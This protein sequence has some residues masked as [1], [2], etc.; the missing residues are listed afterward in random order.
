MDFGL[1]NKKKDE[2]KA[3]AA[4]TRLAADDDVQVPA[5]FQKYAGQGLEGMTKDDLKM[6][7]LALAQGLSPQLNPDDPLYIDG[8]KLGDAYNSLTGEVYGRGPWEVAVVRRDVPRWVE[9]VPREEGGGIKDLNV[10]RN[11][12]RCEWRTIDGVRLPP[13]A[14]QFY[15]YVIVFLASR[16]VIAASFKSTGIRMTAQPWNSLLKLRGVSKPMFMGKYALRSVM[17]KNPKGS[18]AS[19]QVVNAGWVSELE[20]LQ[21]LAATFEAFREKEIVI[22]REPGADDDDID[23]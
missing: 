18:F 8:L 12:S 23:V 6:P 13:I 9:F 7:R 2:E 15:D 4:V 19:L 11:D 1:K 5:E 10:P 3:A 22:D 14:T 17:T 20:T 21:F 16:E